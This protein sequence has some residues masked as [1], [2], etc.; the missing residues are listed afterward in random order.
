MGAS[1]GED[2]G[3]QQGRQTNLTDIQEQEPLHTQDLWP[4]AR[5]S[6]ASRT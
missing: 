2:T 1:S 5:P 4:G 3:G 6:L